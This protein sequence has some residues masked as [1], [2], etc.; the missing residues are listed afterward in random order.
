MAR[1][2][3]RAEVQD[4]F[5]NCIRLLAVYWSTM[6][7]VRGLATEDVIDG[8]V[9]SILAILDGEHGTLPAFRVIPNPH[10]N[11][12]A[13]AKG[14]HENWFPAPSIDYD[15]AGDLHE[16]WNTEK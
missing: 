11:D 13:F 7:N 15:I 12:K 6:E 3:T 16:R 14:L 1:E 10:P 4:E 2:M 8:I 9:F 5:L